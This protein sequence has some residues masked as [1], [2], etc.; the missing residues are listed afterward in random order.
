[1]E[2][3]TNI[4]WQHERITRSD[5]EQLLG[6]QGKVVWFT[7][8]S[9]AGKSTLAQAL[10]ASLHQQ[11][12]LAYTLDGDNIRHGLCGNLGFSAADRSENI[13]RTAEVAKMMVDAGIIVLAA[14]IT[15]LR[16]EQENLRRMLGQ[17]L[18]VIYVEC[19]LAVCESRDPKNLYKLAR[20][21]KIIDFTGISSPYEPPQHPDLVVNTAVASPEACVKDLLQY[22]GISPAGSEEHA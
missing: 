19:P 4:Y 8:L 21:G 2:Q 22:L 7:G 3:V 6:Q 15:P 20:A 14:F 5:R 9:G 12:I 1:M 16:P 13:R 10:N 17:D 11:G 18:H